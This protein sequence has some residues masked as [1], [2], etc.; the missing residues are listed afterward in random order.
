MR[1]VLVSNALLLAVGI[2]RLAVLDVTR[3]ERRSCTNHLLGR[4]HFQMK[5]RC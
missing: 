5:R 4:G 2:D 3:I 1:H